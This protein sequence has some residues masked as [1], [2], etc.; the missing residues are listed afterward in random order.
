MLLETLFALT[1]HANVYDASPECKAVQ[2]ISAPNSDLPTKKEIAELK[3]CDSE[4][5]YYGIGQKVDYKKARH[6]AFAQLENE[7]DDVFWGGRTIL[8]MIYANGYGVKQNRKLALK[9][10]CGLESAPAEISGRIEHLKKEGKIDFCDDITSGYAQGFCQSRD[11][12]IAK[13]VREE[14]FANLPF[15][16]PAFEKLKSASAEFT[17][18]RAENEVDQSGT[19]RAAQQLQE[20]DIQERDFLESLQTFAAGKAPHFNR[21]KEDDHLNDVFKKVMAFKD[22]ANWWGTVTKDNILK[23]Q[24]AWI[25]YRNAWREFAGADKAD[26][27]DAWFTKKRAHMLESFTKN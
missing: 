5:P 14:K 27:V 18:A 25:K 21:K 16:G 6:C 26:Q 19:A 7:E 10:A 11:N 1:A 20:E 3:K 12:D 8:Y 23:T 9:Y 24:R 15:K 2:H 17:K 4:K 13:A 22:P